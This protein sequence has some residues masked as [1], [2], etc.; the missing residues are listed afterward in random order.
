[1]KPTAEDTLLHCSI[2][3]F[4]LRTSPRSFGSIEP[5][6]PLNLST[7]SVESIV[8]TALQTD[9]QGLL[10]L[11][12][13]IVFHIRLVGRSGPMVKRDA[14][15]ILKAVTVSLASALTVNIIVLATT[16][17]HASVVSMVMPHLVPRL[18]VSFA[19]DCTVSE[20][21]NL[22]ACHCDEG[23]TG[24]RCERCATGWYGEPYHFGNKC[25]RCF[26]NDN[27]DLSVENA[28]DS[29]SGRCLFCMNNTDGFY[30]DECSPWFYGDAK[31][32]KNCTDG[33]IPK[34]T[35]PSFPSA[36]GL[37]AGAR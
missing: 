22:L 17:N 1:M 2:V 33:E 27:N 10:L 3:C 37:P 35:S 28:C 4:C 24:E 12:P 15:D 7:T 20:T 21:G 26:C 8:V 36:L 23:Y 16:A 19:L 29:R 30:C 32:G 18:I 11:V 5:V 9:K 31:D 13:L 34:L 25:Q 6:A 14:M